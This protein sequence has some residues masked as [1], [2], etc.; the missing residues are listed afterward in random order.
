MKRFAQ[1]RWLRTL[2][3]VGLLGAVL[4]AGSVIASKHSIVHACSRYN[5]SG[6]NTTFQDDTNNSIAGTLSL[7]YDPCSGDNYAV[8][9]ITGTA[10]SGGLLSVHRTAGNGLQDTVVFTS[11][12]PTSG[13]CDGFVLGAVVYSPNNRAQACWNDNVGGLAICTDLF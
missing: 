10:K 4:F 9:N 3:V 12:C 13:L 8:L 11:S 7:G 2:V 1:N 6:S 5:V